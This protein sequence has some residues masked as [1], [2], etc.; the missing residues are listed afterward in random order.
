[1]R[2]S[3]AWCS[4]LLAAWPGR[5]GGDELTANGGME[6]RFH[7]GIA[8]GW[9]NNCWG[10]NEATFSP[11]R[12]H[13]G[14]ASQQVTCTSFSGGAV[15]F[16]YPLAVKRAKHYKVSLWARSDGG[17]GLVGMGLRQCPHPYKMHLSK[18]F[19]P[20]PEW[21]PFTLEGTSL[22]SDD[23]AGLFLWFAP[24]GKGTLWIDDVSVTEEEPQA[25]RLPFPSGNVV[26][27]GSF[28]VAWQRDWR[29]R[30]TSPAYDM[31]NP[32]HGRRSLR[33][34]VD[35]Q[36]EPWVSRIV[37]FGSEGKGFTL[38]L[39]ARAKGKA[40]VT[41]TL[42][43]GIAIDAGG[44]LL[45]LACRP[46][47]Q[48]K[49]FAASGTVAPS[50]NGGYY[51]TIDIRVEG[52]ADV[53]L[54]A[55]H[56]KP[57]PESAAFK[58][59]RTVEASLDCRRLAHIHRLGEPVELA[60]TAFNDGSEPANC[61]WQCRVTDYRR[62]EVT[63]VPVVLTIS[64]HAATETPVR[65]PSD[66]TGVF[67]A[68]LLD[69]DEVL[70]GLSYSVLPPLSAVPGEK[71]A[72][73]G[74]FRL[75]PFHLQVA[76]AMGIRWTRIHDCE[77]VTHWLTAEPEKGRFVW[78]DD[79]VALAREHGIRV[80]G[81]FL[82]V[83]Q[84]ASSAPAEV[85]GGAVHLYPPRDLKQFADYVL[86][87]VG[88]Y[89]KD[90]H[91]WEIW[92]EPYG[93]GFWRGTPEQYAEL[94][95]VAAAAIRRADPEAVVLAPCIHPGSTQWVKRALA[96][97]ATADA[98]VFSY[99]GYGL[100]VPRGYRSVAEW[101]RYKRP[102]PLPVWN[103]ETG[104][105]SE[106]FLRNVPDRF[107]DGYTTWLGAIPC[108]QAAEQAVKLFVLAL[109]GGAERYFHYW[110]V[111]EGTMLPRLSAMSIF[112]YDGSLRPMGVGYAVAVSLLDGT[113]G[114]GW[115]ELPG[116]AVTNLLT[117]ERRAI[118]VVWRS[119][120]RRPKRIAVPLEPA[121]VDAR[122]MMGSRLALPGGG[123]R[124]ELSVGGEPVYLIVA[125]EHAARLEGALTGSKPVSNP[126][127]VDPTLR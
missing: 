123:D 76:R 28:E 120:G 16:Y 18:S 86:A 29:P 84:W 47:T 11:G 118:A 42:W 104:V 79:K 122:D 114:R 34:H 68:E 5:A 37:E 74:H 83:P 85:Q 52:P 59:R 98:D 54:D 53:W 4:I 90:I 9:V 8:E 93:E 82:R 57:G 121:L 107:V 97:G 2:T 63:R 100:L 38:G 17:V 44:P 78:F 7:Q 111:Y 113:R 77:T 26:P 60:A 94:A 117:D 75:D 62:R 13:D 80:L 36:T 19:E 109:A 112:E 110:D 101:S 12:P 126:A 22:A 50:A 6:G 39:A 27:N 51:L 87:V 69:G 88:H 73:G 91:H 35:D 31:A 49:T 119:A 3:L 46:E 96:A 108:D 32:F 115:V 24:D 1:M 43:P 124:F 102:S 89:R 127:N 116:P 95:K 66:Q 10:D 30:H 21:E 99:H 81:E 70:S 67:L 40:T 25:V 125:A 45:K 20:G 14:H 48:W 64:P 41:A 55:V 105:S 58:P 61:R 103:S 106:S 56:L 92:N 15:Q 33:W 72:A 23:K 65:L 71:S